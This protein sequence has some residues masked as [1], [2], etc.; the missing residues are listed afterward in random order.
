[1]QCHPRRVGD[2]KGVLM[3]YDWI[4]YAAVHLFKDKDHGA[5]QEIDALW[6]QI[7]SNRTATQPSSVMLKID[8]HIKTKDGRA[9]CIYKGTLALFHSE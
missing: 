2:V 6:R 3:E 1:M 4:N 9:D 5:V 7:V 8:L